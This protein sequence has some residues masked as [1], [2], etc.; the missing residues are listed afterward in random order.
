VRRQKL[1]AITLLVNGY[2]VNANPGLRETNL[3]MARALTP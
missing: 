1:W 2:S 3:D